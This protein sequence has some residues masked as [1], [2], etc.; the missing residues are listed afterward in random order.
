MDNLTKALKS[1]GFT[2]NEI[3]IYT[4]LLELGEASYTEL[5]KKTGIKRTSLYSMVS[6]LQERGIVQAHID[7][8]TLSAIPPAELFSLLQGQVLQLHKLI[9]QLSALGK[10]DRAI[11]RVKFYLGSENIKRAYFEEEQPIPPVKDRLVYIITGPRTWGEF[12]DKHA[13]GFSDM[14][15]KELKRRG[16]KLFTLSSGDPHPPFDRKV[17]PEYNMQVKHL[18]ADYVYDFDLEIRPNSIVISDLLSEQP[19]AVKI[20]STELAKALGNF[21]QFTWD[22]YSKKE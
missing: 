1:L 11:S 5:A 20:I 4:S 15:N 17:V 2:E 19:Y 3:E 16:Y 13:P 14:Y 21:F 22:L 6:D 12:W 7:S 9:P 10:K 8:R 18:P